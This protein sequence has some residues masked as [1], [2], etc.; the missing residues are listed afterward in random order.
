M[1]TLVRLDGLSAS[2]MK[3]NEHDEDQLSS[4]GW[5]LRIVRLPWTTESTCRTTEIHTPLVLQD[6]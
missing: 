2:R 4:Q 6:K 3:T 5:T 1:L